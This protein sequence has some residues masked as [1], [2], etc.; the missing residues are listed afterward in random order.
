MSKAL[1]VVDFINDIIH[2][3]GKMAAKGYAA[4]NQRHHTLDKVASLI[5]WARASS[6]PVIHIG[7]AF[8][9]DYLEH[10]P[11][12]PL[13]GPAKKNELARE[14]DWGS[15]F[16]EQVIPRATEK[17]ITKRRVS[18]FYNTDLAATLSS[19][20]IKHILVAGVAT[21]MAVQSLVRDAHDR[22]FTCTVIDDCCAAACDEDHSQTLR[23]LQ[24]V[25]AVTTLATLQQS[26]L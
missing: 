16:H 3:K 17:Q 24:N 10:P 1:I 23:M 20:G 9:S 15:Q 21:D 19:L 14:G 22:D 11:H 8:S 4:F 6:V 7:L 18:G 13:F 2:E 25:S 12:S 5:S 26:S